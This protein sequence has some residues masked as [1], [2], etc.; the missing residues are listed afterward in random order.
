[1]NPDDIETV[2]RNLGEGQ[3]EAREALA[4]IEADLSK[5]EEFADNVKAAS[6]LLDTRRENHG[7]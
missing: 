3:T 7:H 5:L 6:R 2:L 1:M 4:R